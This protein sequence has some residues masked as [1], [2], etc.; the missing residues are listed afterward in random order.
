MVEVLFFFASL[1]FQC[2]VDDCRLVEG[3]WTDPEISDPL[4]D[5]FAL[6][7]ARRDRALTQQWGVWL[8][9]KDTERALKLLTTHTHGSGKRG[10][11]AE[12]EAATLRQIG[13]VNAEAGVRFLEHLVLQKRRTDPALHTELAL[14]YIEEVLSFLADDATSKLWRAKAASYASSPNAA[15]FLTYFEATT[16]ASP[17]KLARLRTALF[18]QTSA[19]YD[20][21]AAQA[22][23]SPHAPLLAP[24]LAILAGKLGNAQEALSLLALTIHD[25]S[26]ATSFCTSQGS[27]IPPHAASQL[28]SRAGLGAW[29][30][31]PTPTPTHDTPETQRLLRLLLTIYTSTA[32]DSAAEI[33]AANLLASYAPSFDTTDVL[34]TFR[35]LA[36]AALEQYLACALRTAAHTA[37]ERA[38][39]KAL[40][41]GQNLAVADVAHTQLRAAGALV[42]EAASDDDD[43]GGEELVLDE[44][45]ALASSQLMIAKTEQAETADAEVVVGSWMSGRSSV[46]NA[47][48]SVGLVAMTEIRGRLSRS[49]PHVRPQHRTS[50]TTL[51]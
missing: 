8:A 26:S 1:S 9:G 18:L 35:P 15:P 44:K 11:K 21:A 42:E 23:F 7:T 4:S 37:H 30:P 13:A 19:A 17:S 25:H 24:E 47:S 6:L 22:R 50:H 27:V 51:I 3:E 41:A 12:D 28:A 40:A 45:E 5:M 14:T 46:T 49:V 16:P 43:E 39:V 10:Q 29:A 38:L 48:A 20:V 2:E 34:T 32:P 33:A 36:A 31:T